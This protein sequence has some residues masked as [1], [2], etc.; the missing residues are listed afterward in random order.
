MLSPVSSIGEFWTS[1]PLVSLLTFSSIFSLSIDLMASSSRGKDLEEAYANLSLNND[2][3]DSLILED[4]RENDTIEGLDRYVVGS[5]V[6]NKKMN[7]MAMHDMLASIWRS[8]KGVFM[9]ETNQPNVF[10]FMFFH[11]RDMQ[12]SD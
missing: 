9:E 11:D 12:S 2:E 1:H 6:T 10:L 8:V 7:S 4:I 3:E 5:F